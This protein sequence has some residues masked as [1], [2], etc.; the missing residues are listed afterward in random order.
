M[1]DKPGMGAVQGRAFYHVD[2]I[3]HHQQ[4]LSYTDLEN[5][6]DWDPQNRTN[7]TFNITDIIAEEDRFAIRFVF[8]AAEKM[9]N[10]ETRIEVIYFYHLRDDKISE[11][12][13]LA[14]DDFDYKQRA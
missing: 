4:T 11:F 10:Q 2:V 3:G 9:Q 13:L 8:T 6:L 7:Q 5:R 14:S 12:W 1:V